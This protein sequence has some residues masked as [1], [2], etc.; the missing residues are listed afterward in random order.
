MQPIVRP[1]A[2]YAG[3]E[4]DGKL[5]I[6]RLKKSFGTKEELKRPVSFPPAF[7]FFTP[8]FQKDN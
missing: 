4:Q 2:R 1:A 3:P 7:F 5:L 6:K 8:S